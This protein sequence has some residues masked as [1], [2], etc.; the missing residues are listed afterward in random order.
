[1]ATTSASTA[2][3]KASMNDALRPWAKT[4]T[5]TTRPRPIISAAAV[6]A[7]RAGLRPAFS[8]AS[9]PRRPAEPLER[10]AD[11]PRQ[12]A[13]DVARD[14]GDGDEEQHRAEAHLE[15]ARRGRRVAEEAEAHEAD[16]GQRDDDRAGVAKRLRRDGGSAAPSCSAATGGTR[17]AR[18]AGTSAATSAVP[19]PTTSA[20]T[21]VRG[22]R[23]R[24]A[25]REVGAERLEELVDGLGHAEAGEQAGDRRGD[26]HEQRLGDDAESAPGAARRRRRAAWRTRAAAGRR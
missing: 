10:P 4:A 14:H 21:T 17:V 6:F 16:A 26:A 7:V 20:T 12:R 18:S 25:T 19:M 8:R 3:S 23:P 15:Q 22:S 2:L 5:K 24:P 1:M 9:R 11:D 13:H